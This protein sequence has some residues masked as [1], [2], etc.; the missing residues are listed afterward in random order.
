MNSFMGESSLEDLTSRDM[1]NRFPV[2]QI[3]S[4]RPSVVQ[5][6]RHSITY[7]GN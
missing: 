1:W 6:V 7:M 3:P 4:V 5:S 2:E